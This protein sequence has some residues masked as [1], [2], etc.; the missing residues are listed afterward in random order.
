MTRATFRRDQL[1]R[2][3]HREFTRR[4]RRALSIYRKAPLRRDRPGYPFKQH[5]DDGSI[6][7]RRN[8]SIKRLPNGVR[9]RVA[10]RGAPFIEEGNDAGG[11][12]IRGAN[13]LLLPLKGGRRAKSPTRNGKVVFVDNKPFLA[14]QRVRT[15]RGRHLLERS[16]RYA[17]LGRSGLRG[18]PF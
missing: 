14:V 7:D 4:G 13:G 3:L 1:E 6:R 9:I 8:Q 17:F 12:Y 16:V 10:S 2:H 15:Y 5:P 11:R 18:G